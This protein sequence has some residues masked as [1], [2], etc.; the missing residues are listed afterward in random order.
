MKFYLKGSLLAIPWLCLCLNGRAQD[1]TAEKKDTAQVKKIVPFDVN[2]QV[3]SLYI[4]RGFKVSNSPITDVDMHYNLTKDK[5]LAVGFWGGAGFTGDYKE[6]DYYISYT[7]PRY[8]FSIW[9]VNNFSDFPNAR[10][11]NYNPRSTSHFVDVR[12]GYKFGD[13]FPLSINWA[14]IILG[15]DT[16][17]TDNGGVSNSYSH[18]SELD[19]RLWKDGNSELHVFV[20]GGFAFGRQ[21]NFYGSKPNVVNTGVTINKDL[22]L[23][24]YHMPIAATAMF[25]PEK[26]YGALQLVVNVF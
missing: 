9:D 20:G 13:S 19:Y 6:F 8:S 2:L 21:E 7:K 24:K 25:N 1:A 18:Y 11:F 3:R 17:P 22:V 23:F 16:H 26:N 12:A 15:R 10:L 5:S 4:W 14:T